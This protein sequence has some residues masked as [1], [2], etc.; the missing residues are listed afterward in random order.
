M[1]EEE[2]FLSNFPE[3]NTTLKSGDPNNRRYNMNAFPSS[4]SAGDQYSLDQEPNYDR[5]ESSI[6]HHQVA[7]P[8]YYEQHEEEYDLYNQ[9]PGMKMHQYEDEAYPT[10]EETHPPYTVHSPYFPMAANVATHP[11]MMVR[12]Q[13]TLLS[14]QVLTKPMLRIHV[15][16]NGTLQYGKVIAFDPITTSFEDLLTIVSAKFN[17]SLSINKNKLKRMWNSTENLLTENDNNKLDT[18]AVPESTAGVNS[19]ASHSR[20]QGMGS[21][22]SERESIGM[23]PKL[24]S[25]RGTEV[26]DINQI[27]NNDVFCFVLPTEPFRPPISLERVLL[28]NLDSSQQ[29]AYPVYSSISPL[30][31]RNFNNGQQDIEVGPSSQNNED[32]HLINSTS[33]ESRT[34]TK[35]TPTKSYHQATFPSSQIV[36][37]P[38]TPILSVH[39]P[40]YQVSSVPVNMVDALSFTTPIHFASPSHYS[41][42]P[43]VK[44]EKQ[45]IRLIPELYYQIFSFLT[46]KELALGIGLV[47]KEFE[48]EY[49]RNENLWKELCMNVYSYYMKRKYQNNTNSKSTEKAPR[50]FANTPLNEIKRR[51]MSACEKPPCYYKSW[52]QYFRFFIHWNMKICWDTCERGN[53]IKFKNNNATIYR[54]DNI[55]YH[56][57]TVRANLSIRIP[58]EQEKRKNGYMTLPMT[59]DSENEDIEIITDDVAI[60]EFEIKIE[61]FDKSNANGWWIVLGVETE[62]FQY[63]ESTPTNL[64]GYDRHGGFGYAGGNG[65]SLHF[66]SNTHLKHKQQ[67][68]CDPVVPWNNVPFNEGDVVKARIKYFTKAFEDAIDPK[69]N[70]GAT[71]S[72]YVNG[73]CIGECFRNMTGT[74]Y[75]AVSILTG[76]SI[77][78]R[79][80]D[81]IF[82]LLIENDDEY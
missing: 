61:K 40:Q 36:R 15:Y 54:D 48:R 25:I 17:Y 18:T 73:K 47:C 22:R 14:P 23:L 75:P 57:Q 27:V 78:L 64:I 1:E 42:S 10:V 16:P 7:E 74:L 35:K 80:V 20:L 44:K 65:D 72:W 4:G 39:R 3:E 5:D 41:P 52:K 68:T 11:A 62:L 13:P 58:S 51:F 49:G 34:P 60:Y 59:F 43:R 82:P 67:Y 9:H 38:R 8:S 71:L 24:I 69:N 53:N 31:S 12:Q 76:Q 66:Y 77:T 37:T 32:N 46:Y 33:G 19:R 30:P 45:I 2:H 56:W 79:A 50:F 21:A 26:D 70:I 55:T 29:K 63:K 28:N 6:H 81:P